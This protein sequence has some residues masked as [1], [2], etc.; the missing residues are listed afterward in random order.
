MGI[1]FQLYISKLVYNRKNC[2]W[3]FYDDDYF[4][5]FIDTEKLVSR[6]AYL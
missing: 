5:E 2:E 4:G 1:N 6:H 3:Y